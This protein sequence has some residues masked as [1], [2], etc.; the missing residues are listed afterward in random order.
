MVPEAVNPLN[1]FK[2]LPEAAAWARDRRHGDRG[3]QRGHRPVL[4]VLVVG[5][6][7]DH[8]GLRRGVA[9]PEAHRPPGDPDRRRRARHLL[10]LRVLDD[11]R[12][13]RQ[14]DRA[15]RSRNTDSIGL[16]VDL[17][18]DKLGGSFVGD[19]YL[20]LI[21][22]GSFACA[23]AFHTAA[24]RYLYAI[25]RELPAT[26]NT[27]GRTHGTHH[28]PHVASLMQSVITAGP[29]PRLLLPDHRR[30]RPAHRRVHLPVRPAG[31]PRHDGDP[32]RAGDHA[33][34]R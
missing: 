11:D 20:F 19:I 16:W 28:T 1:A 27:L 22:I 13:Q 15:S 33:R 29:H 5:R 30:R 17:A 2:D 9:Q 12:R 6:L 10:H 31:D 18:E 4:R 14:G 8:R 7:R 32:D 21:V 25:G 24:S 23:L 3:R 34:W 26:A